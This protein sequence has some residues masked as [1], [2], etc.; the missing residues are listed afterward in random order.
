V[1]RSDDMWIYILWMF[2]TGAKASEWYIGKYNRDS[3]K[4]CP[5]RGWWSQ[6]RWMRHSIV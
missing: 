1:F 5:C 3:E 4:T 6:N 2:L